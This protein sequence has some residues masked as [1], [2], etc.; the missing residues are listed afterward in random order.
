MGD[1]LGYRREALAR[2]T[3]ERRERGVGDASDI[4]R[5]GARVLPTSPLNS[6]SDSRILRSTSAPRGVMR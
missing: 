2:R 5:L 3:D 4:S 6:P 1:V